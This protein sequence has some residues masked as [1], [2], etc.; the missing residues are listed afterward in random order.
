[1]VVTAFSNDTVSL[2]SY[3]FQNRLPKTSTPHSG[4]G[5]LKSIINHEN[6]PTERPAGQSNSHL[7]S[8]EVSCSQM[9]PG[10]CQVAK[11]HPA[12]IRGSR[13]MV[14]RNTGFLPLKNSDL[15]CM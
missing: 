12:Q 1:M 10:L 6:V 7:V 3:A 11:T 13:R 14:P 15:S 4:L 2:L 5:F 9:I 8:G